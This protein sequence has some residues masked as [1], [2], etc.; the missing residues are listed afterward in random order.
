M[1]REMV[2]L[3]ITGSANF[4]ITDTALLTTEEQVPFTTT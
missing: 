4:V 3:T 1:S 2:D